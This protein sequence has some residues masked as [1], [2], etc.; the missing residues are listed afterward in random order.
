MPTD[1][2]ESGADKKTRAELL[3]MTAQ[4][5]AAYVSH[6]RIDVASLTSIIVQIHEELRTLL[7][8]AAEPTGKP[9]VPVKKSIS[10]D[11][12]VCLEDGKRLRT[13]KRYLRSHYNM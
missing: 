3:D 6:N 1:N 13:L 8:V 11:Y 4:M 7:G 5:T 10:T 12:I 2:P 9:A